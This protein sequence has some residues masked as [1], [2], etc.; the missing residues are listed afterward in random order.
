MGLSW[1]RD[2]IEGQDEACEGLSSA[3]MQFDISA[4]GSK[5]GLRCL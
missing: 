2:G 3:Q 5:A 1:S 4:V